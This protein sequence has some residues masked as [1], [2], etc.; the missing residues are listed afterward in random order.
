MQKRHVLRQQY[1]RE[2]EATTRLHYL[3]Y[4]SDHI[5]INRHTRVLE[6]GCGEGGNLLPFARLGCRVTGIDMAACRIEEA[7][8]YFLKEG[9]PATW[10]CADF[11]TL[12]PPSDNG[13][14]FDLILLHDVLEHIS[15]K[16][17]FLEHVRRFLHPKGGYLPAFR[18]G[19]CPLAAT[20]RFAATPFA[21]TCRLSTCCRP[22]STTRC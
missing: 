10:I 2:Q 8:A 13:S 22:G 7:T 11:M 3:P 6:I 1:F 16:A 14:R 12:P 17:A 15:R 21:P 9:Y 20:S 5:T 4:I 19:R 18:P